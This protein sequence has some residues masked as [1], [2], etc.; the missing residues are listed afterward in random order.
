MDK[1]FATKTAQYIQISG[2]LAK[3]ALDALAPYQADATKAAAEQPA[4][5]QALLDA[6]MIEP[7][8]KEAAEKLLKTQAGQLQLLKEAAKV[9]TRLAANQKEA[10][11]LGVAV[12]PDTVGLSGSTVRAEDS[13]TSPFVG[14]R[15]SQKKASDLA[16]EQKLLAGYTRG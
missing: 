3:R 7:H 13:L 16:Y 11:D 4:V 5:V 15:T 9:V 10:A 6:Q 1:K 2:A 8:Q 12:D 14:L